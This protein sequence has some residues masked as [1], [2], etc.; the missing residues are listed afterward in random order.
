MTETDH[1]G[2]EEDQPQ[3][4]GEDQFHQTKEQNMVLNGEQYMKKSEQKTQ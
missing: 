1:T 2:S 4:P 3:S